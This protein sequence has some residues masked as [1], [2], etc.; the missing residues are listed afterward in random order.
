MI[1]EEYLKKLEKELHKLP[2][3]ERCEALEFYTEYLD[4]AED[5]AA[6]IE[7][8]GTP[9]EVAR[10]IMA[11]K[12]VKYIDEKQENTSVRKGV[13]ALWIVALATLS[14]IALLLA[15]AFIILIL[16]VL[17]TVVAFTLALLAGGGWL[18]WNSVV[19]MGIDVIS[20]LFFMGISLILLGFSVLLGSAIWRAV[21]AVL[22]WATLKM[23][24]R[25]NRRV[26][27]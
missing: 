13:S 4:D 20:G 25:R 9:K 8:L 17:I 23:N 6:A 18:L 11:D 15:L 19:S 22:R 16:A 7:K 10:S 14:P 3:A 12:A 5:F 1:K 27:A 26:K 24:S 2:Q 21:G